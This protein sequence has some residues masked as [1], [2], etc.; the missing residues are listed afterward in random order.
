MEQA[1]R[2]TTHPY[3]ISSDTLRAS[4]FV[5]SGDRCFLYHGDCREF[6]G[7]LPDESVQLIVTSPPYNIGKEYETDS[8]LKQY[9]Q[10]QSE[11][12]AECVRVLKPEGSIC[13]EVG[14]HIVGAAEVLPLD[15]ALHGVFAGQGL[16]LRNRIVW[17]FE[18]GLHCKKRFSGRYE[19]IMW[20][21]KNGDYY[22]NLDPV[23]VPQKYPGKRHFKGPRAGELSGNPLGKN[24]S[25]VWIFPNVKNN[26][27]E[28]TAH[29]CQF[30]T[31]L[32]DR[33]VLALTRPDDIVLDPF[34]GVSSALVAALL[35]GRRSCGAELVAEYVDISRRRIEQ[36]F[37]GTLPVR[38]ASLPV[39][40]P[41]GEGI[42]RLPREFEEVRLN[43]DQGSVQLPLC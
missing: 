10:L 21:T 13:W 34:A 37:A 36:A 22:F 11:V 33:L 31:E 7:A 41:R 26:H 40:S 32:V 14:N 38:P 30:P 39:Y 6:L 17:H 25:D 8:T 3:R 19:V 16:H 15:I 28:K 42:A 12:I 4:E 29:P 9:L 27:R 18:H 20:Y 35:R 1:V 5:G 24:P 43:G 23:R 2:E